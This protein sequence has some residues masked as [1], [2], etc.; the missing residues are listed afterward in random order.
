MHKTIFMDRPKTSFN[1]DVDRVFQE[2]TESLKTF[3]DEKVADFA[4]PQ[5]KG[6]AGHLAK[7]YP[8]SVK[9]PDLD[10]INTDSQN[11]DLISKFGQLNPGQNRG[12]FNSFFARSEANMN[13]LSLMKII[14]AVTFILIIFSILIY[15]FFLVALNWKREKAYKNCAMPTNIVNNVRQSICLSEQ[16]SIA[17]GNGNSSFRGSV[18]TNESGANSVRKLSAELNASTIDIAWKPL[19]RLPNSNRNEG[20]QCW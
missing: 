1:A 4:D 8:D 18:S 3:F 2:L 13:E 17:E 19:V 7:M 6:F 9:T 5:N 10:F 14:A 11:S 16:K 12:Y 15:A 20:T